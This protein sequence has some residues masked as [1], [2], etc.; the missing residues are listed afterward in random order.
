M[1]MVKCVKVL[2]LLLNK[3]AVITSTQMAPVDLELIDRNEA[4]YHTQWRKMG[5]TKEFAYAF[6]RSY[7]KSHSCCIIFDKIPGSIKSHPP[8][9]EAEMMYEK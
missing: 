7:S 4:L 9:Y 3:I 2:S 8:H 1:T 6:C 5:S